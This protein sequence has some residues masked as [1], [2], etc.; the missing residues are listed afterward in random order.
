MTHKSSYE[1]FSLT[2]WRMKTSYDDLRAFPCYKISGNFVTFHA[3]QGF[4]SSSR[5][6]LERRMCVES[7]RVGADMLA[8][9]CMM[10]RLVC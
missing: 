4:P 6:L 3:L 1:V 2:I 9:S 7:V 8:C 5:Q 10:T